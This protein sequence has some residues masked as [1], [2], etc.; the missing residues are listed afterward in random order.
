[1][2][3]SWLDDL[4]G[5]LKGLFSKSATGR[6]TFE[7]DTVGPPDDEHP[8][9]HIGDIV[10]LVPKVNNGEFTQGK[11]SLATYKEM[12][13]GRIGRAIIPQSLVVHTTDM[14]PGTFNALVRSWTS[15]LGR[16]NGAH[17]LIGR[18]EAD[19]VVQFASI[20]RNANHAGGPNCGGFKLPSGAYA[21]PN[22]VSIGVEIDNA[23]K[24]KKVGNKWMDYEKVVVIPDGDVYIDQFGHGWHKPTPY[25]IDMLAKLWAA[26]KPIL[27]PWPSGTKVLANGPYV[28]DGSNYQPWAEVTNPAL[29]GHCSMNAINKTDPGPVLMTLIKQWV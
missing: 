7:W 23:G 16:G 9:V 3:T 15:Q 20:L 13:A 5:K 11:W 26:V 19:G 10:D 22:T 29:L 4:V 27:K 18:T 24:L 14:R 6:A 28:G 12:F 8:V 1:M 17:F 25:Q 2:A 21:H